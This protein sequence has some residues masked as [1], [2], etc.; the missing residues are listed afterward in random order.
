MNKSL[1]SCQH[2]QRSYRWG[3]TGHT[4]CVRMTYSENSS[5]SASTFAYTM[6]VFYCTFVGTLNTAGQGE[7]TEF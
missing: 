4:T 5:P 1:V 7:N 2:V 6:G 3:A